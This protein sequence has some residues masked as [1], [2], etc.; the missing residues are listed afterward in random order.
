LDNRLRDATQYPAR[1]RRDREPATPIRSVPCCV[2]SAAEVCPGRDNSAPVDFPPLPRDHFGRNGVRHWH[3]L[4]YALRRR[5]SHQRELTRTTG[6]RK[7]QRDYIVAGSSR[8]GAPAA[9]VTQSTA[10]A[11]PAPTSAALEWEAKPALEIPPSVVIPGLEPK[12]AANPAATTFEATSTTTRA[13][14]SRRPRRPF[15]PQRSLRSWHAATG[16]WRRAMSLRH[17]FFMSEPRMQE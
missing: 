3:L 7:V 6:S 14:G 13:R 16:C 12:A 9:G 5:E 11:A 10:L 2:G 1:P 15:L 17:A 4:A 8:D